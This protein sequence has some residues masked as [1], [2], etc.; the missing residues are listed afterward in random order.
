L[1]HTTTF[2]VRTYRAN[3]WKRHRDFTTVTTP[4]GDV[5]VKRGFEGDRVTIL[6]PEFEDCRRLAQSAGVSVQT[7]YDAAKRAAQDAQNVA[8]ATED[9]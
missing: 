2:G 9:A 4:Y 5:R 7:V 6:S 8:K 1:A 3:R